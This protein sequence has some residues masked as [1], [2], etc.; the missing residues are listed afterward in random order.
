MKKDIISGLAYI[1]PL[2]T[3]RT[4]PLV[5]FHDLPASLVSTISAIDR[6]AHDAGARSPMSR[7]HPD[8]HPWYMHTHQEDNLLVLSGMRIV[9]LYTPAHGMLESFEV[10]PTQIVHGGV[11]IAE[12]PSILGWGVGVFHRVFSPQGSVSMNFA[13]HMPGFDFT[14]NFNIYS[15]ETETGAYSVLRAGMSDQPE[16]DVGE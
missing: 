14:T 10:S 9:E 12:G 5:Q 6:V 1:V 13:R 15:L 8:A 7:E 11:V 2:E 4:T 16:R 3:L